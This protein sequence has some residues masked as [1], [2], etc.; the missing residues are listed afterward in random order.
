MKEKDNIPLN[1]KIVKKDGK[2]GVINKDTKEI[3]VPYGNYQTLEK[4]GK[5]TLKVCERRESCKVIT[6]NNLP[7]LRDYHHIDT[8]IA[9]IDPSRP[10]DVSNSIYIGL[11][12]NNTAHITIPSMS[13]G[14]IV[15]KIIEQH[16]KLSFVK[17]NNYPENGFFVLNST[18]K[19]GNKKYGFLVPDGDDWEITV[20][21]FDTVNVSDEQ[22]YLYKIL[23]ISNSSYND[24][25]V[26]SAHS[27]GGNYMKYNPLNHSYIDGSWNGY[28]KPASLPFNKEN[29][30]IKNGYLYVTYSNKDCDKKHDINVDKNMVNVSENS[31]IVL[32]KELYDSE[33]IKNLIPENERK[34]YQNAISTIE[35]QIQKGKNADSFYNIVNSPFE[36]ISAITCVF[37]LFC[38]PLWP[39]VF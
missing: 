20:P 16:N 36:F 5:D 17:F 8:L 7:V 21:Q 12:E 33:Q 28:I 4:L 1:I 23:K 18:D 9:K 10:D 25:I 19:K 13:A 6:N 32:S 30:E 35:K 38:P 15:K 2:R 29:I 26:S 11:K 31:K 24:I 37:V 34:S 27:D 14:G 3:I 39:Y 22:S